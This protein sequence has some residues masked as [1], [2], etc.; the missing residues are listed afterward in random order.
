[1]ARKP[2]AGQNA[3]ERAR[4]ELTREIKAEARRQLATSGADGLSLRAVARELGMV[5]SALYRYFAS[6]DDLLTALIIDAYDALGAAAEKAAATEGEPRARWIAAC[7]AVRSWALA[8]PQEYALIYGSPV[9]GYR[10]PETTIAPAARVPAALVGILRDAE[11]EGLPAQTPPRALPEDLREQAA[12]TTRALAAVTGGKDP[13]V[14]P[15][16]LVRGVIAWTQLAGMVSFEL[17]GQFANGF[18]P[19]DALFDHSAA[20]MAAFVIP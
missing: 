10:A 14:S 11:A 18:D 9:P 12:A 19:A 2:N 15:E 13:G 6:R 17:F 5:S 7:R 8:H 16:T 3:R 1:M 20:Q 4:A